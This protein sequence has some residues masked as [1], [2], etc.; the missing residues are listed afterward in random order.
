LQISA[1]GI[2]VNMSNWLKKFE[3]DA[4]GVIDYLEKELRGLRVGRASASLVEDIVV[5][6]YGN[7]LNL[8]GVANI[9]VVD[10]RSIAITP[11]DRNLSSAVEKAIRNS[12]L[13]LNPVNTGDVI[14]INIPPLTEERRKDLLK[15]VSQR[16]E[17]SK[18]SLRNIRRDIL[19]E[20]KKGK[21]AGEITEDEY[22]KTEDDLNKIVNKYTDLVDKQAE[23]KQHEMMEV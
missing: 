15:V 13:G 21:M 6:A 22:F 2:G 4:Q 10:A 12:D 7:Q 1:R 20:A 23:G 8:K 19:D 17:E 5:E 11:R 16:A 3:S 9:S 14:R 18:V